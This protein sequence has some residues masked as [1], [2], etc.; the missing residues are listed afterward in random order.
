MSELYM[1]TDFLTV[2][3][4]TPI[5]A[6]THIAMSRPADKLYDFILVTKNDEYL[7]TVTIKDLLQ[8][9]TEIEV[10]NAKHQNPLSGL[11]GNII[12]EQ[13]MYN[14]SYYK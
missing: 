12:I 7:G 13:K 4:Q 2:D 5:N 9:T 1:E 6:V 14:C 8:K 11:P 3:S 10:V